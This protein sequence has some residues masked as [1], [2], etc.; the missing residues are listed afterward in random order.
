MAD[1]LSALR[2]LLKTPA[3][4]PIPAS[5]TQENA[6]IRFLGAKAG[7]VPKKSTPESVGK[8]AQWLSLSLRIRNSTD[9]TV[10]EL[11]QILKFL[12]ADL[13][14]STFLLGTAMTLADVVVFLSVPKA[15]KAAKGVTG[16][17]NVF[18]YVCVKSVSCF[19]VSHPKYMYVAFVARSFV[20]LH[21]PCCV[22]LPTT[23]ACP[24]KVVRPRCL[25]HWRQPRNRGIGSTNAGTM[26]RSDPG[27][28][29][30]S[31]CCVFW[32]CR[33]ERSQGWGTEAARTG[34][35][36][37]QI[38]IATTRHGI[39]GRC[40]IFFHPGVDFRVFPPRSVLFLCS[41]NAGAAAALCL[42][43]SPVVRTVVPFERQY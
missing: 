15:I 35:G 25:D 20:F 40:E 43:M 28:A 12:N 27:C 21:S 19:V 36:K 31:T 14:T 26:R 23:S 18:R 4:T 5:L 16:I 22:L 34:W 30:P 29:S 6:Q 24:P 32:G 37:P 13:N 9:A 2:G 41:G 39:P 1:F 8:T 42:K 3:E 17:D 38:G 33:C 7:L 10:T 11:P